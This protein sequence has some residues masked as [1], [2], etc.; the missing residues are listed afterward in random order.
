MY[1]GPLC[2]YIVYM[3]LYYSV[4]HCTYVYTI[5]GQCM[6]TLYMYMYMHA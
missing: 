3:Y 4:V 6:F 5:S 1:S 2:R